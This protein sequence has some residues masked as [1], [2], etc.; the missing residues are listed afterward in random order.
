MPDQY[1]PIREAFMRAQAAEQEA[2]FEDAIKYGMGAHFGGERVKPEDL[3]GEECPNG[4]GGYADT[5]A[6]PAGL[7]TPFINM[8]FS[9]KFAKFCVLHDLRCEWE[10]QPMQS[11]LI[12]KVYRGSIH[13]KKPPIWSQA[14]NLYDL[15]MTVEGE[16][17]MDRVL[18]NVIEE[19]EDQILQNRGIT[20]DVIGAAHNLWYEKRDRSMRDSRGNGFYTSREFMEPIIHAQQQRERER[21]KGFRDKA[22][23]QRD[24]AKTQDS[25]WKEREFETFFRTYHF[26][27][28]QSRAWEEILR[29]AGFEFPGRSKEPP[30][31][32]QPKPEF[33]AGKKYTD[34][35]KSA[36]V[37]ARKIKAM[38]DDDRADKGTRD[39]AGNRL[40]AILSKHSLT[41]ADLW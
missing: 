6:N 34:P 33:K 13:S 4:W 10:K 24:G 30:P 35:Q 36:I 20:S 14:L 27:E 39:A 40:F 21:A 1:D 26:T 23:A 12:L 7:L 25:F 22:Q 2:A 9:V 29:K 32:A 3:H 28:E 5:N 19:V 8:G 18:D 15:N 16:R 31:K 11:A 17:Y 37:K 38:R 41:E